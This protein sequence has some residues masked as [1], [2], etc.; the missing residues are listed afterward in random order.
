MTYHYNC[1]LTK[2]VVNDLP[3]QL[4]LD[5]MGGNDLQSTIVA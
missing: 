2:Q 1:Y 4:L 3:L 5:K